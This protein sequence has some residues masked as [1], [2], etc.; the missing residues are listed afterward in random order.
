MG[1]GQPHEAQ[2]YNTLRI[3]S[4]YTHTVSSSHVTGCAQSLSSTQTH[5]RAL[6]CRVTGARLTRWISGGMRSGSVVSNASSVYSL[7]AL[8]VQQMTQKRG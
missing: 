7:Y 1:E 4:P 5:P 3:I 6:S 8:P 2:T